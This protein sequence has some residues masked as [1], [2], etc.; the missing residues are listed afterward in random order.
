MNLYYYWADRHKL[1]KNLFIDIEASVGSDNEEEED[2]ELDSDFIVDGTIDIDEGDLLSADQTTSPG[3]SRLTSPVDHTIDEQYSALLG[4][5]LARGA[6]EN[7]R[8]RIH[9]GVADALVGS[10]PGTDRQTWLHL[11]VVVFKAVAK[12]MVKVIMTG[13]WKVLAATVVVVVVLVVV[14]VV[15][16]IVAKHPVHV[17]GVV[18]VIVGVVV[19]EKVVVGMCGAL[20]LV[21][22]PIWLTIV[23]VVDE[24]KYSYYNNR[25][26]NCHIGNVQPTVAVVSPSPSSTTTTLEPSPH[27]HLHP[28][29]HPSIHRRSKPPAHRP[30]STAASLRTT[31]G[32]TSTAANTTMWHET[33]PTTTK[34]IAAAILSA[35]ATLTAATTTSTTT[36]LVTTPPSPTSPIPTKTA[37]PS[38]TRHTTRTRMRRE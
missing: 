24:L 4:R 37:E 17:G 23:V 14:V 9:E 30:I 6:K 10:R 38:R 8:R 35:V 2:A 21:K 15:V 20:D 32:T 36:F 5:A 11:A 27:P 34:V 22:T 19:E 26:R 1:V 25:T 31:A 7:P 16:V 3:P 13:W 12:V 28:T 33:V 18:M 29:R